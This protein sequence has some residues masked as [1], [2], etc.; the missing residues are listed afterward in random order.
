MIRIH[1]SFISFF[2]FSIISICLLSGCHRITAV[3]L[4]K[5]MAQAPAYG[6]SLHNA[7]YIKMNLFFDSDVASQH[8]K[9]FPIPEGPRQVN[10]KSSFSP[11]PDGSLKWTKG[12]EKGIKYTLSG[13]LVEQNF[14][15][16]TKQADIPDHISDESALERLLQDAPT[17]EVLMKYTYQYLMTHRDKYSLDQAY[18]LIEK[19]AKKY[20]LS[21]R[22]VTGFVYSNKQLV[23]HLWFEF[24]GDNDG[25]IPMDIKLGWNLR[26]Y[27][28]FG[29]ISN[30][31]VVCYYLMNYK[32][33]SSGTDVFDLP[34][35]INVRA[36]VLEFVPIKTGDNLF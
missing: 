28:Y 15:G 4:K 19:T 35:N 22:Y 24:L 31:T 9:L 18:A 25:Y 26:S 8:M 11:K 17:N 23:P 34:A 12:L 36:Q 20:N 32:K 5:E 14:L 33:V 3:Q 27:F 29:N 21:Y 13:Y 6:Y 7:R 1:K 30:R 10:M 2:L 16:Q